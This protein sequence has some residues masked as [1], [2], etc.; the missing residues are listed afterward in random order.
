MTKITNQIGKNVTLRGT[1]GNA[2]GG[3]VIQ[4]P[5]NRVIYIEGLS[6]WDDEFS[7]KEVIV[8]GNLREK[9]LIPDPYISP[10]GGI[11]QGAIGTQIVLE[12]AS[13]K[14]A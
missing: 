5:D 6:G 9:K 10:D 2:K 7:G 11:S 8:T 13:W 12:N 14:K 3:A 4:L 1:A